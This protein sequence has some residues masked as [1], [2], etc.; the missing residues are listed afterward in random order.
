MLLCTLFRG[1][2]QHLQAPQ[3]WDFRALH[4]SP[5]LERQDELERTLRQPAYSYAEHS[6]AEIP[7]QPLRAQDYLG[8]LL[9]LGAQDIAMGTDALAAPDLQGLRASL[10]WRW[11]LDPDVGIARRS[12][13]AMP[14]FRRGQTNWDAR[15]LLGRD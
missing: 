6:G 11:L 1:A 8:W 13:Q 7:K 9:L 4:S 3:L 10:N 5:L 12:C 14:H 2:N 15:G